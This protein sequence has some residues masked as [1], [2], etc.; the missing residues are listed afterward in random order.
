VYTQKVAGNSPT[1]RLM[2][3]YEAAYCYFRDELLV[4]VLGESLPD[5]ILTFSRSSKRTLAFFAPDVWRA[6]LDDSERRHELGIV[7]AHTADD[8]REVM[9]SLVH[10]MLHFADYVAGTAPKSSGYHGKKWA[11]R[12]EKVGLPPV[13]GPNKSRVTVSHEIVPNGPYARAY[14]ALPKSIL[15]P[16]VAAI[17]GVATSGEDESGEDSTAGKKPPTKAGKRFK[18]ACPKCATTMRGPAGRKLICGDCEVAYVAE[19]PGTS[20]DTSSQRPPGRLNVLGKDCSEITAS[21]D[22]PNDFDD[23]LRGVDHVKN[24]DRLC[25]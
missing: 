6:D 20:G 12:M 3:A 17:A 24:D 8:P 16:F 18:Y 25:G 21:V 11:A 9:A 13:S 23:V 2:H 19:P 1:E 5:P 15:L 14:D 7:P 22:D 4:P 10:E